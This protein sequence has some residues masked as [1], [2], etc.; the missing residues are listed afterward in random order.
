M[1]N[2]SIKLEGWITLIL[3]VMVI[4]LLSTISWSLLKD[5]ILHERK[6]LLVDITNMGHGILSKF[7]AQQ[8]KGELTESE[9]KQAAREALRP[10]RYGDNG[11]LFIYKGST[12]ILA[13]ENPQ[14]EGKDLSNVKDANGIYIGREMSQITANGGAGFLRYHWYRPETPNIAS[15][16]LSYARGFT[17]WGW[18]IGTG[19]YQDD[20]QDILTGL[21]ASKKW[22]LL[23]TAAITLALVGVIFMIGNSSIRRVLMLKASMETLGQGD[24]SQPI[25][26][27]GSDEFGQMQTLLR[28]VQQR[29]NK[30]L[31]SLKHS[32]QSVFADIDRIASD[33]T[34]LSTRI[35]EQSEELDRIDTLLHQISS[36]A[37]EAADNIGHAATKANASSN[38]V[39]NGEQVVGKAI[40]AMENINTSSE[41]ITDIVTV[42]DDLAFQTNLLALNAAV[43][44]ARAGDAGKGFAVVANEVRNLAQRS[45]D[46]ARQIRS[47]IEESSA[48]VRTGSQL[49]NESGTLLRGIVENYHEV[50]ERLSGISSS[51][52]RQHDIVEQAS[53][54]LNRLNHF[55][56]EN[57]KLMAHA[58]ADSSDVREHA[59]RMQQHLGFF[60]LQPVQ[61][62]PSEHASTPHDDHERSSRQ[63]HVDLRQQP[64]DDFKNKVA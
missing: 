59:L 29:I 31:N 43:E 19:V 32:T 34:T 52:S 46:A 37:R 28:D 51:A 60:K 50:A 22:L 16:K 9:A 55:S 58:S 21:L 10:F 12:A 7:H 24:F 61:E 23:L 26:V 33:N 44:A 47:L 4:A 13:P 36:S 63:A 57:L 48:N 39:A 42:I 20:L 11:Y 27:V 18:Y 62:L 40:A 35:I 38:M 25:P 53:Q 14:N 41:R 3:V 17:P 54:L 64:D 15:E 1:K 6:A 49:V 2:I 56:Q 8:L 5:A 30:V 45:A